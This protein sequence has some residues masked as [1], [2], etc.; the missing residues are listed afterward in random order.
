MR[1][2]AHHILIFYHIAPRPG[3][4]SSAPTGHAALSARC[5]RFRSWGGSDIF[6]R[7]VAKCG[8]A[9]PS[10]EAGPIP[11]TRTIARGRHSGRNRWN[12]GDAMVTAG[13]G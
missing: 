5:A 6:L 4:E 2:L 12:R 9:I 3:I 7:G 11:R 13:A 1:A 8:A 10:A